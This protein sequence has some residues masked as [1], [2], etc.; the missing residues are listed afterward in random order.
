MG[1]TAL[2]YI[3]D[4]EGNSNRSLDVTRHSTLNEALS[5]LLEQIYIEEDDNVY[6]LNYMLTKRIPQDTLREVKEYLIENKSIW[7]STYHRL[8]S[9]I[10]I[11]LLNGEPTNYSLDISEARSLN[12][13]GVG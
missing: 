9:G 7:K 11:Q 6:Y 8:G 12:T 1:Y 2:V 10:M 5:H 13:F 4:N 3:V